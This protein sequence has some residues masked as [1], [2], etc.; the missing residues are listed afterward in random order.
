VLGIGWPAEA[1]LC[2]LFFSGAF[3]RGRSASPLCALCVAIGVDVLIE[4]MAHRL[5]KPSPTGVHSSGDV[6]S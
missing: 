4:T 1:L 3:A 2:F 6:S 5:P